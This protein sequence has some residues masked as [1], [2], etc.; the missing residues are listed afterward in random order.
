MCCAH[1]MPASMR[2]WRGANAHVCRRLPTASRHGRSAPI[3]RRLRP[4]G[5][6]RKPRRL[7]GR[8]DVIIS[9]SK[10]VALAA[11]LVFGAAGCARQ[12]EFVPSPLPP[13]PPVPTLPSIS[14]QELG[15]VSDDVYR[16]LVERELRLKEFIGQLEANC[17]G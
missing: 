2:R 9:R 5:S 10:T 6:A 13:C 11:V 16:R 15:G 14:A 4:S 7:S 8:E 12:V 17:G 1:A 3:R